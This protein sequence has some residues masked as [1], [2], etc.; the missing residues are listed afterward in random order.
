MIEQSI[1]PLR[2]LART[3]PVV[4]PL[5]LLQAEA[6][7]IAYDS[8]WERGLPEFV[9][10][11]LDIGIPLLE[12]LAMSVDPDRTEALLVRLGA[13]AARAMPGEA[14]S[15][16][17]AT[18][19]LA[20]D[21]A[22]SIEASITQDR[23]WLDVAADNTGVDAGLLATLAHVAALPLLQACGRQ[24]APLIAGAT[25]NAGY[26]PVCAGWPTLCEMRG[27]ERTRWLRCGRCGA[28][29]PSQGQRCAFCG[30][31]N[32][33]TLGYLAAEAERE[34]RRAETCDL[35]HSYL[36]TLATLTA[37]S[38]VDLLV[39]DAATVELDVAAINDGYGRPEQPG[40]QLHVRVEPIRRLD[41]RLSS[42]G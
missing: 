5:A 7:Q 1:E 9:A 13:V 30:N 40:F 20:I 6:L 4:A 39:R 32:H 25:W 26:C 8:A 14:E 22:A 11:G 19:R 21:P 17:R 42:S 10:R 16:H 31:A 35:C 23:V 28:G 27:L 41:G 2:G 3:D 15:F 12:G 38:S 29:W 37:L 34:A 33:E 36:K 18:A 24:A